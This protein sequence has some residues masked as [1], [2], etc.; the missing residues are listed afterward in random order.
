MK[1]KFK[2]YLKEI[3]LSS[4]IIKNNVELIIGYANRLCKEE[5][6]DIFVD[7]Y[8]EA[9]GSRGYGSLWLMSEQ[10]ICEA[11]NFRNTV[12]H[13]IDV[14]SIK[15][16]VIYF[17]VHIKDYD[18]ENATKESRFMIECANETGTLFQLKASH[19][20]CNRLVE[21]VDNYIKPNI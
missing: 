8:Y 10:Y 20:N 17:R 3:D 5:I 7:D 6:I 19:E 16:A 15:D 4:E 18:F 14:T 9:D 1:S 2:A 13:D 11:R 21:I 12:E